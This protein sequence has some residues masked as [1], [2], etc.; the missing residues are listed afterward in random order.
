MNDSKPKVLSE[1]TISPAGNYI[2]LTVL[3]L[4]ALTATFL[5]SISAYNFEIKLLVFIAV[6]I[7]YLVFCLIS[8]AGQKKSSQNNL[9]IT[10]NDSAF[11][12]EIERKLLVLEEANRF[13][14]ASL[15][16]GDMFRLVGSRINEI[17]PF[18]VL[19][20][21]MADEGNSRL[22][23]VNAFGENAEQII[24]TEISSD[25]G[26]AGNTFQN[27][28]ANFDDYLQTD[29]VIKGERILTNMNSAI[30]VPLF[31]AGVAYGVLVLYA[32]QKNR[33]NRSL[34]PLFENI[35]E[36]IA[37][38]FLSSRVF[39]DN[40]ANAL[41][42]AITKLPNER[43]FYLVLENQ[44]AESQRF[45]D[46]RPLTVLTIDIE[47]FGDL[48]RQFGHAAGDRILEYA[49]L[50]IRNQLRQMDFL[51]RSA[52][53]EFLAVLP[54]A[55]DEITLEIV[56]RIRKIFVL[57]PFE[58]VHQELIHLQL[59]F[60]AASFWKD[61]ETAAQLLKH[62]RLRKQQSKSAENDNVLWFP[63]EFVN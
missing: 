56:E 53:D 36:R 58:V 34:L 51:A 15:K 8:Y 49:A 52:G 27:Q 6:V 42:D 30:S 19:A 33:L 59:H 41:T 45:R 61:G 55:S 38:L 44:I 43:A 22:K 54:T 48:N 10:D 4:A 28:T 39:E 5:V 20:L 62:A 35:G 60:G 25:E 31:Q 40:L 12:D 16:S 32:D 17:I 3:S 47:N 26:L 9:K 46:E 18:S 37:P 57:K 11:G 24:G 63:K 23:I 29:A 21:F 7:S 50:N 13:F 14:G 2:L 1:K